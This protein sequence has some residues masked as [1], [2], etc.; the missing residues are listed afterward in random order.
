MKMSFSVR[1]LKD[2]AERAVKTFA[3]VLVGILTVDGADLANVNWKASLVAAGT[4]SAVS[5]L[6]SVASAKVGDDESASL[7]N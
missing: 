7:V 5:L 4:A 3:Q 1:F 6:T 2:A